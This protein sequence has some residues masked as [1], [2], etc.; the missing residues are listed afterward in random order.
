MNKE[1]VLKLSQ[2]ENKGKLDERE[3]AA[4][5]QASRVGMF[6]GALLCVVLILVSEFVLDKPEFSFVG[7]LVYFGMRGSSN[8]VM[9]KYLKIRSKLIYGIIEIV[10]AIVFAVALVVKTVA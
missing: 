6:V 4:F 9:F 5:G 7:W 8:I 1:D 2:Q 3:L 10:C